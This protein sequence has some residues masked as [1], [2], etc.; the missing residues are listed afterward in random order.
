MP[1][2]GFFELAGAAAS[3]IFSASASR[4]ALEGLIIPA[5]L[6]LQTAAKL[7]VET[8]VNCRSGAVEISSG[9]TKG[10]QVHCRGVVCRPSEGV[11]S[12]HLRLSEN[13]RNDSGCVPHPACRFLCA[14]CAKRSER[15][16]TKGGW[17]RYW[18]LNLIK[19]II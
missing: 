3:I 6:G 14:L 15:H 11:Y 8:E 10:R 18:M 1:G 7:I 12:R 16:N 17:P 13:D 5:P 19:E 2:A 4:L 9:P